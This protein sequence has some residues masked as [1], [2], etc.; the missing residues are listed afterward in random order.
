MSSVRETA[1]QAL[2]AVLQGAA[3]VTVRRNEVLPVKIPEGGLILL[4]D[5]ELAV[6][7]TLLSPLRYLIQHRA[8]LQVAVQKPTAS[9]R[10]TALDGLLIGIA[11]A[12]QANPTL[13][14]TVDVAL[15]EAP[16]FIEEPVEGAA[17]LK[18]A[19]VPVLLEYLAP[20]PIS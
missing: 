10:D 19:A 7:E 8:E 15:L 18:I 14:G 6:T 12:L 2:L 11:L 13:S 4:F 5:G 1:L 9:A 17:G 3:G 16:Q 20:T